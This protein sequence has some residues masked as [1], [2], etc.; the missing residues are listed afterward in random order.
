M[1]R[2]IRN[3]DYLAVFCEGDKLS[4]GRIMLWV[5]FLIMIHFWL[6]TIEV[7]ATLMTTFMVFVSYNLGK[8]VQYVVEGWIENGKV[9]EKRGEEI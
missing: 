8:K 1:I 7:P 9:V 6:G 2:R 5:T 3:I 4:I